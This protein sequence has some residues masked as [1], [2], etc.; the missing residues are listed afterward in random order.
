MGGGQHTYIFTGDE[1][2]RSHRARGWHVTFGSWLVHHMR[3][4]RVRTEWH[5]WHKRT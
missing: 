1:R 2:G 5:S 3:T 4:S